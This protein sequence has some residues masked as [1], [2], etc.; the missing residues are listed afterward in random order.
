MERWKE[1]RRHPTGFL[2]KAPSSRWR[3]GAVCFDNPATAR[4]SARET[5]VPL[6]SISFDAPHFHYGSPHRNIAWMLPLYLDTYT[7]NSLHEG[8]CFQQENNT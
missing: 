1:R 3:P 7:M 2:Y 4:T 8:G 6:C 5:S